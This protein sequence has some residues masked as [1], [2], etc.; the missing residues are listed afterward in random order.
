MGLRKHAL[1]ALRALWIGWVVLGCATPI[2]NRPAPDP[3]PQS[4]HRNRG[5]E[6]IFLVLALS[7]GGT[8]AAA[9]AYGVFEELAATRVR[10][11]G[12]ERRLLD[13]VDV[14]ESVSGGS[15]LAAWYGL[16]GDETLS[17]FGEAFLY[18][19]FETPLLLRMLSPV[20]W[21]RG[22]GEVAA[23]YYDGKL[24]HGATLGDFR[25]EGPRV[26]I[27][28]TDLVGETHFSFDPDYFRAICSD[29]PGFPVA[30]AVA[31]SSA[32]P[33]A[34]S[35]IVLENHSAMCNGKPPSWIGTVLERSEI[36]G[37]SMER[38]WARNFAAYY[39]STRRYL[40]LLDGGIAG[41]Q[42]LTIP[43]VREQELGGVRA[44]W[45]ALGLESTRHLLMVV[46]NASVPVPQER[47]Q[48]RSPPSTTEALLDSSTVMV[49]RQSRDGIDRLRHHLEGWRRE[50]GRNGMGPRIALAELSFVELDDPEERKYFHSVPTSLSLEREQVDR[51]R[52]VGRRLLRDNPAYRELLEAYE[53]PGR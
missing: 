16:H 23:R 47:G 13:E 9:L 18:R 11:G 35:P 48:R 5:S 25:P 10:V 34:F 14:I 52:E 49:N 32:V 24:F 45:Q 4:Q 21:G 33:G 28:S 40:H 7:G 53:G 19:D 15:F 2:H 42:G 37:P 6:E 51:L 20:N 36:E 8:R 12:R 46:V 50:L 41:N 43:L 3:P 1:A 29:L 26:I 39:E 30:P 31:A 27:T 17:T 44:L 38:E 22:R